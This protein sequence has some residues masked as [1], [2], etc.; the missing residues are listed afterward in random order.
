MPVMEVKDPL[1]WID[2]E[3]TG[4]DVD[5]DEII[6]VCCFIT[7]GQLNLV[8]DQGWEGVVHLDKSRLDSMDEWCTSTHGKSGLIAASIAS[9]TTAEEAAKGLLAYIE[10]YI[11]R[12]RTGVLAGN[13]VH[14]DKAFL[15]K[16]PFDCVNRHL[17]YRILDVSTIKEAARRWAPLEMLDRAPLKQ[18]LHQARE[19]ILESIAEAKFY[20]DTFFTPKKQETRD[21]S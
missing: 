5:N 13:S 1:I 4:L 20:R 7:D 9:S 21:A 14:A 6:S 15:R 12:S 10:K 19:D 3:M 8:D 11:P 17:H 2:C 16:P 18:G